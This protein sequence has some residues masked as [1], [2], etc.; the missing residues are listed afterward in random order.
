MKRLK[1]YKTSDAPSGEWVRWVNDNTPTYWF[2]PESPHD[3]ATLT[4]V[5]RGRWELTI[6]DDRPQDYENLGVLQGSLEEVISQANAIF[7]LEGWV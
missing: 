1:K 4:W 2:G 5:G 3:F 6:D 7:A